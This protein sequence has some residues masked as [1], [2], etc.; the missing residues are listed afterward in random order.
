MAH[1]AKKEVSDSH[2][3]KIQRM[4]RH[5]GD[6]SGPKNN[7]KAPGEFLKNP[8]PE[9]SVG[10]GA[11]YSA[12]SARS[13]RPARKSMAANPIPTYRRGGAVK[14]VDGMKSGPNAGGASKHAKQ[15]VTPTG[16]GRARGGRLN[17]KGKG[18]THVNVIVAPQGGNQP[19]MTP[20][21]NL[22][23][24][25]GGAHPPMPAPAPTAPPMG[26][27]PMAVGAPPPGGPP[28]PMRKRGGKITGKPSDMKVI[29]SELAEHERKEHHRARGGNVSQKDPTSHTMSEEG[30][31]QKARGGGIHMTAGADSGV[32]RLQK[33]GLSPKS[34]KKQAV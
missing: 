12:A 2:N 33:M 15:G 10:F 11:D 14:H 17:S 13:D 1:P 4:T 25:A 16:A 20:P 9:E 21:P 31:I 29:A 8:G 24:L 32:G 26:G 18:H 19:P 27:P 6:A 34:V 3:A 5:Y 23:A 30:L 7:I 28:M 22:A